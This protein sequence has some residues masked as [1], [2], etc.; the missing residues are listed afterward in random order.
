MCKKISRG[1]CC[2][3]FSA[4]S[5]LTQM[6]CYCGRDWKI[7]VII[8]GWTWVCLSF[9]FSFFSLFL[10]TFGIPWSR[11]NPRLLVLHIELY[12]STLQFLM[13]RAV[14]R[15]DKFWWLQAI[16]KTANK[17]I[18]HDIDTSICSNFFPIQSPL[19]GLVCGM[20]HTN[21]GRF[22]TVKNNYR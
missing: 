6:S 22:I 19:C 16:H 10:A 2:E 15:Q 5:L 12:A 1:G 8:I 14:H 7:Y 13:Y 18:H 17:S 4:I 9:C 3:N 20:I 11:A 21:L